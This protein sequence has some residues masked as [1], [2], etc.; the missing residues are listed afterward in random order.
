MMLVC[1]GSAPNSPCQ[2]PRL[3]LPQTRPDGLGMEF[4]E[5][6]IR[7]RAEKHFPQLSGTQAMPARHDSARG[8]GPPDY[9]STFDSPRAYPPESWAAEC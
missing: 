6:G 2:G 8:L 1:S 4:R 7:V 9:R 3:A 5:L